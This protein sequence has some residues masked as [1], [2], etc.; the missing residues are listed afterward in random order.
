MNM[1]IAE[2]QKA[3]TILNKDGNSGNVF[4]EHDELYLWPKA[5]SFTA[6]EVSQLSD[7]GFRMNDEGGFECFT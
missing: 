5:D 3:L 4:A 7:L 2:L 6:A 1:D